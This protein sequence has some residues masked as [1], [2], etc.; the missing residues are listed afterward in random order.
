MTFA[1]EI[2]RRRYYSRMRTHLPFDFCLQFGVFELALVEDVLLETLP[3][4][5]FDVCR[6]FRGRVDDWSDQ[7]TG[8]HPFDVGGNGDSA[9]PR[10][11]LWLFE[12]GFSWEGSGVWCWCIFL[13]RIHTRGSPASSIGFQLCRITIF[14]AFPLM[15]G[16]FVEEVVLQPRVTPELVVVFI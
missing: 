16:T 8:G 13:F 15:T 10:V 12:A 14:R 5:L 9:R 4:Q 2:R 6:I 1:L 11:Y 7:R 3:L